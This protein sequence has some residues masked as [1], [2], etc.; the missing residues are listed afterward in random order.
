MTKNFDSV[1]SVHVPDVR[2][3]SSTRC[4]VEDMVTD[5]GVTIISVTSMPS[6]F[7]TR[8]PDRMFNVFK[9]C[10]IVTLTNRQFCHTS[11]KKEGDQ[12]GRVGRKR[13]MRPTKQKKVWSMPCCTD[14][15]GGLN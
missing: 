7:A 4:S 12:Y 14:S 15:K 5:S 3:A 8:M 10:E 13:I 9:S 6:V 2:N 11:H 1:S